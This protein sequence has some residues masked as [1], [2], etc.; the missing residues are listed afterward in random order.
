MN[1]CK[2]HRSARLSAANRV[3]LA[4]T[5]IALASVPA[6]A[7][8]ASRTQQNNTPQH[9]PPGVARTHLV[10]PMDLH[11]PS[12]FLSKNARSPGRLPMPASTRKRPCGFHRAVL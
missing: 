12:A 7:S 5:T 8:T 6:S 10:L 9:P 11:L 1:S 3:F 2:A 4:A